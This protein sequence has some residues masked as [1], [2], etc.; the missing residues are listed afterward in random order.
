M[1][2]KTKANKAESGQGASLL[3]NDIRVSMDLYQRPTRQVA[4][5]LVPELITAANEAKNAVGRRLDGLLRE[6]IESRC[7]LEYWSWDNPDEVKLVKG[8]FEA[9]RFMGGEV[10]G[11]HDALDFFAAFILLVAKAEKLGVCD[12]CGKLYWNRRGRADRRFCQRKCAQLQTAKEGYARQLAR[13]RRK[14]NKKIR[15]AINAFIDEKP[16]GVGWKVW[17]AKRARVTQS[18]LTR[19]INRGFHSEPDGV[20]LTKAQIKYLES[21]GGSH[22]ANL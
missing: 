17:V 21:R 4:D 22:H 19:A 20:K 2:T 7:N 13:E 1:R 8:A 18:Y 5:W 16:A 11:G 15:Q 9:W 14:K 12:G 6:W 10:V 3:E